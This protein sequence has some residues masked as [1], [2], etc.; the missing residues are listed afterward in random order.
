MCVT[1]RSGDLGPRPSLPK[2][3]WDREHRRHFP[4]RKENVVSWVIAM[5]QCPTIRIHGSAG[6]E[7]LTGAALLSPAD[8]SALGD[9]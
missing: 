3:G 2:L 6:C 7:L 4:G 1:T 9:G 5:Q 8:R